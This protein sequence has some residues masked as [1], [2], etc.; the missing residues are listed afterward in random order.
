MAVHIPLSLEAQLEARVLMMS[1][2]N[3]LSPS[4]G[5]PIIVPSQDIV[6]GLYYLSQSKDSDKDKPVGIFSNVEEINNALEKNLISVH[7]KVVSQFSTID[8]NG[9]KVTEKYVSTAGRFL[10]SETLPKHHKIK[11]S[12]INKLLTKKIVS[13]LIDIVYRFCGQKQTV[14]F[15]DKHKRSWF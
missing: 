13:E 15:C 11:F 9:K 3:I 1:T 14:I 12:F 6:L 4:N 7:S 8:E 5:K 10:L 2:N